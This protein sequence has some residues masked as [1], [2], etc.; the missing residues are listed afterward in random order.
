[1]TGPDILPRFSLQDQGL[2]RN[3]QDDTWNK[4]GQIRDKFEYDREKR[5]Q[6][7]G[8]FNAFFIFLMDIGSMHCMCCYYDFKIWFN[9]KHVLL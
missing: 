6:Q 1:M 4:V 5:M 3:R 8:W 9:A 2:L 7:K